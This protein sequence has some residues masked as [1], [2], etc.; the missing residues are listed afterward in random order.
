MKF[1]DNSDRNI[2]HMVIGA[3]AEDVARAMAMTRLHHIDM[4]LVF[5]NVPIPETDQKQ[6]D[7]FNKIMKPYTAM[8][9]NFGSGDSYDMLKENG[10]NTY[11]KLKAEHLLIKAK[12]SKLN[13]LMRNSIE[14]LYNR[15][16]N[17]VAEL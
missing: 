2:S 1:K 16:E 13:R 6:I 11:Q 8:G 14:S 10:F 15:I 4:P 3:G 9:F 17:K 12:E 7:E 5:V